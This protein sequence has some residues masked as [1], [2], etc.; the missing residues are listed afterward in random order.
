MEVRQL[1]KPDFQTMSQRELQAYVLAHRDDKA[2][3]Y[4]YVDKLHADANWVEMSPFQSLEDVEG[5]AEFV[6]HVR[7]SSEPRD[8]AV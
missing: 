5:H 2:A 7:N 4:A 3:F 1:S 8:N 6:E